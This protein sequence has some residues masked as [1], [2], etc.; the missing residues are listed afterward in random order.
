ME[1]GAYRA[2]LKRD[3]KDK[4]V[5]TPVEQLPTPALL[6]DRAKVKHN[7]DQ[8]R[9]TV[10]AWECLFRAHIKTHKTGEGVALQLSKTGDGAIIVSTLAEAWGV[11]DE[12]D[13][14]ASGK[15]KSVS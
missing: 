7:I 9:Q 2:A 10:E 3:L 13:L 5:G 15:V 14:L 6:I 8:M 11:I 4:Y 1:P 12:T